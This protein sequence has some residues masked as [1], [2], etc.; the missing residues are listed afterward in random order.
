[1]KLLGSLKRVGA[2]LILTLILGQLFGGLGLAQG[3]DGRS[4]FFPET[5]YTVSGDFLEFFERHGGIEIFGYPITEPFIDQGLRVQYFQ[6]AR[7]ESHPQNP[8]PYQVLL[9]LLGNELKYGKPRV[10]RPTVASRRRVYFPETGHTLAFAFLD[11]FRDNGGLDVFGYPVTEMYFE[12]GRIVQYF[13]RMKLEWHPED[14]AAPVQV[15]NLGE[16]YVSVYG[17]RFSPDAFRLDPASARPQPVP[18]S[19]TTVQALRAVVSLRY[20]VMG[21]Q[22]NQTVSVLVTDESGNPL[23]NAE[24]GIRFLSPSGQVLGSKSTLMTDAR[25][26][27]RTSIPVSGGKTGDQIVARA[28]VVYEGL[29]TSAENVFLLWW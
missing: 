13:Q 4:R 1:M 20:S 23:P 11:F 16:I 8:E 18:K 24:V 17:E 12:D 29:R 27:V 21:R 6:N 9:G 15:G 14:R 7:F 28:N 19:P 2:A 22:G 26:F 10:S 25:G 5:G 3:Q